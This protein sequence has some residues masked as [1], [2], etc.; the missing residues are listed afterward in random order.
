MLPSRNR[1]PCRRPDPSS[2]A[3]PGVNKPPPPSLLVQDQS[4]SQWWWHWTLFHS[5]LLD[6]PSSDA[7]V[8]ENCEDIRSKAVIHFQGFRNP[9]PSCQ[10]PPL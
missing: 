9:S 4:A 6:V 3:W 1:W 10:R 8:M 7:D 5:R 2:S